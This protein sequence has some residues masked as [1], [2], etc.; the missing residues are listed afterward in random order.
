VIP[1][2]HY[3]IFEL[4]SLTNALTL[5]NSDLPSAPE[6]VGAGLGL[7]GQ[8]VSGQPFI[9]CGDLSA[10]DDFN[11]VTD[12]LGLDDM[13]S[14]LYA[15]LDSRY[16]LALLSRDTDKYTV[17]DVSLVVGLSTL[18]AHV[19]ELSLSLSTC[20][21]GATSVSAG[22]QAQIMARASNPSRSDLEEF[23][24]R[25]FNIANYSE[26]D[27]L[28]I[29]LKMFVSQGVLRKFGVPMPKLVAYVCAIRSRYRALPYH[30][31]IH[32]CDV[33]QFVYACITRGR[34]RLYLQDLELF[35]LLLAAVSHEVDH[36]GLNNLYQRKAKTPL[37]LAYE[38]RPVMEMQHVATAIGLLEKSEYDILEGLEAPEDKSRFLSFFIKLILATDMDKHFAYVKEFE[39]I[40]GDFD[41]K[42]ERHRLLL[43]QMILKAGNFANTTRSFEVAAEM[44]HKLTEENFKQGDMERELGLEI[45]V[46]C[47]KQR[48]SHISVTQLS[49]YQFMAG[50]LFEMIGTFIPALSDNLEQFEKNKKNWE[51]QKQQW[52]SNQRP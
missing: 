24:D 44:A 31:W 8:I 14:G 50:P 48:P 35:A 21:Q 17:K 12:A 7:L 5:V 10:R 41:K 33:T 43:A 45:S 51:Q 27:L 30:N 22:D 3:A 28:I 4:D 13:V 29:V 23:S 42:N 20:V 18:I 2:A 46:N 39:E 6:F 52:E 19:A 26:D 16:I 36:R 11:A 9:I 47:D 38:E 32:A 1:S 15:K 40:M 37:A 25:L 34:L 49:F